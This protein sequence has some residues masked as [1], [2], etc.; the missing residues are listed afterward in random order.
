MNIAHVIPYDYKGGAETFVIDLI[1]NQINNE[2]YQKI[3]LITYQL[4]DSS[5]PFSVNIDSNKF[6]HYN[7]NYVG[8]KMNQFNIILSIFSFLLKNRVNIIHSHLMG[9]IHCAVI[10]FFLKN[11]KFVHTVH[12][13]AIKELGSNKESIYYILRKFYYRRNSVVSISESVKLSLTKLYEI[14]SKLIINGAVYNQN[15]SSII[16]EKILNGKDYLFLAIGNTRK[17]KNFELLIDSFNILN[18]E[19][20]YK[21]IILGKLVEN[22]KNINV[23][24]Y[25]EKDIYFLGSVTNVQDYMKIADFLCMTSNYEGMPITILEAK[26]N[27]LIPIVRPVEGIL[28]VVKHKYNG[29]ISDDLSV[30]SY[31]KA[32]KEAFQISDNDK[33]NMINNAKAEFNEIYNMKIC[34]SN[35]LNHY[36]RLYEN[37]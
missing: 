18:K 7:I 1:R 2:K 30:N 3:H 19:K 6:N 25:A 20:R 21:L 22:F 8:F 36:K 24:S 29:I 4:N 35:Y 12:S 16:D 9:A 26:A 37:K 5:I 28:D 33:K 23:D 13:Q 27:G 32:L 31:L 15:S 10:S 11:K 14:N 34:S 17:E